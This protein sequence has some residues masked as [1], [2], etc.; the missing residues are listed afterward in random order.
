MATRGSQEIVSRRRIDSID[1]V[2]GLAMVLM[3]LDHVRL[4]FHE[5]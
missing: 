3:A 1:A 2:R 4:F 5:G